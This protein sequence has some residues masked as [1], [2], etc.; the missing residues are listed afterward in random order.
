MAKKLVN[1]LRMLWS[2]TNGQSVLEY[3]LLLAAIITL[4]MFSSTLIKQA[5][6]AAE[7]HRKTAVDRVL[8]PG[9]W[10]KGVKEF[11]KF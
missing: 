3:V 1:F 4:T 11:E 2:S 5:Q 10:P 7:T 9:K 8:G 6:T